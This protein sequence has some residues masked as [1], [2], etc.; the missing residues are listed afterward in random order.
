MMKEVKIYLLPLS[1]EGV[2]IMNYLRQGETSWLDHWISMQDWHGIISK[3][4]IEYELSCSD[5]IPISIQFNIDKLPIVVEEKNYV[6]FNIKWHNYD[7]VKLR[8]YSMM[9]DINRSSLTL[10]SEVLECRDL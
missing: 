2:T 5:H 1:E 6:N 8:E 4:S 10:P 3:L 7:A 9:C